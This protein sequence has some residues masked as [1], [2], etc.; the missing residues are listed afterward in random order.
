M[1]LAT[2]KYGGTWNF[3]SRVFKM[4]ALTFGKM[5]TKFVTM[6]SEKIFDKIVLKA[7]VD[8]GMTKLMQAG[9]YFANHPCARYARRVTFQH[10]NQPSASVEE[11]KN[12]YSGKHKLNGC[13]TEFSILPTGL[14]VNCTD[15]YP[16]S[17]ANIDIFCKNL[18]YHDLALFKS[19]K[20]GTKGVCICYRL[21][22]FE[23]V[24]S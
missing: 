3:L 24:V 20:K 23:C 21:G 4:K 2:A 5:V 7:I 10:A 19:Q 13:K 1:V 6:F 16:G 8:N 11:G 22:P 18:D 12:F 9:K 17:V 14:A 15:H